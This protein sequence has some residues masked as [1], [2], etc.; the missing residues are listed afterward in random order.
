MISEYWEL[1]VE[2]ERRGTESRGVFQGTIRYTPRVAEFLF[3]V[4]VC[5]SWYTRRWASFESECH[6]MRWTWI[7][8]NE[9]FDSS[10]A[11]LHWLLEHICNV[12]LWIRTTV[13]R[14]RDRYIPATIQ[15]GPAVPAPPPAVATPLSVR[16]HGVQQPR[17]TTRP[18]R[19]LI[20]ALSLLPCCP[21]S[22]RTPSCSY[23][24]WVKMVFKTLCRTLLLSVPALT[25]TQCTYMKPAASRTGP[26]FNLLCKR[27]SRL[28]RIASIRRPLLLTIFLDV[29][30]YQFFIS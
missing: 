1:W 20:K 24:A 10:C 13:I 2:W 3:C 23:K 11:V 18:P 30:C 7:W 9:S 15:Y 5:F 28:M 6:G 29:K 14:D 19:C 4:T 17:H 16:P 12:L 22:R 26:N 8:I 21:N 25:R 27:K